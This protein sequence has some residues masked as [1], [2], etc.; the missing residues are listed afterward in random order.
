MPFA[1]AL[2]IPVRARMRHATRTT[3]RCV[4]AWLAGVAL[5]CGMAAASAQVVLESADNTTLAG[6]GPAGNGPDPNPQVVTLRHNPRQP[7]RQHA[8]G[9]HAGRH[10]DL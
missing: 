9:A 1:I 7:R 6:S 8:G 2:S 4:M 3:L 10:G 5:W